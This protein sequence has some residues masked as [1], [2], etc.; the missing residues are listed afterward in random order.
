MMANH[1]HTAGRLLQWLHTWDKNSYVVNYLLARYYFDH[2]NDPQRAVPHLRTCVQQSQ[3]G[4]MHSGVKFIRAAWHQRGADWSL[5]LAFLHRTTTTASGSSGADASDSDKK[6][7][8]P[9][10]N[11]KLL[12]TYQRKMAT[13]VKW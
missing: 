3:L 6:A 5:A 8:N 10:K 2:L 1:V 12:A 4:D 11:E 13:R 9:L 7:A